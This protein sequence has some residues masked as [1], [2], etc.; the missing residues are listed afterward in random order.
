MHG[1][2]PLLIAPLPSQNNDPVFSV[3]SFA[4][5]IAP[6][7]LDRS[8]HHVAG[9]TDQAPQ[10]L[11]PFSKCHCRAAGNQP[12]P[13][14]PCPVLTMYQRP[15]Q[16]DPEYDDDPEPCDDDSDAINAES[17]SPEERNPSLL[18]L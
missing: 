8:G 11:R 3:G 9:T 10:A 2:E 16:F 4:A 5:P 7:G 12:V 17:F 6:S 14:P 18:N 13:C 1:R 15:H